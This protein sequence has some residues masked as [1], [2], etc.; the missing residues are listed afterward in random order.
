[1]APDAPLQPRS[2]SSMRRPLPTPALLIMGVFFMQAVVVSSLYP[3]M[4][5]IQDRLAI[6]PRDLS[7]T[8][9]GTPIASLCALLVSGALI[10]RL[11]PRRT[12]LF[13]FCLYCAAVTLPGFAWNVPSLFVALFCVGLGYPLMDVAMNVEANRIEGTIGR[14]IMSTCHG[15]W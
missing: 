4:P 12:I 1:M 13:S 5:D 14:R 15:F 6:G 9:L 10:E 7:I 3:R 8:L 11:T 2:R